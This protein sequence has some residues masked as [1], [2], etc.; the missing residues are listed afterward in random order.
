VEI[1]R[2]YYTSEYSYSNHMNY[3]VEE[4]AARARLRVDTIRF[5]Q[6]RGLLPRPRREGR[7]AFYDDAHLERLRRIRE[8]VDQGFTL[9]QIRRLLDRQSEAEDRPLLEALVEEHVGERT[10]SR[11][12]LAAEV[13]I[14]EELIGAA[15]AS[16][17]VQPLQIE[18]E[19][20]FSAADREMAH[21]ALRILKAGFPLYELLALA[22]QHARAIQ[23][24]S[25][26]AIDLF[27]DH[28][29]K[30]AAERGDKGAVTEA[31]RDLL[32]QLT[33]LVALHFQR[34]LVSR[35]LQRLAGRGDEDLRAA[36][37]ATESSSLE[38]AWR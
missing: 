19:E 29:R 38:I 5:Y 32:P 13:G 33:C 26:R 28:V 30:P 12:E 16:G 8:L 1:S 24:V 27:D 37:A 9:A 11:S 10:F 21:A 36:L 23:E 34:T 18:G 20:R 31:F 22:V 14:P 2:L 4:I 17:L 6:F 25:D 7:I 35:A 15:E 3:R